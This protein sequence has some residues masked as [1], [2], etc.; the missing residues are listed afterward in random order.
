MDGKKQLL[1]GLYNNIVNITPLL[2]DYVGRKISLFI[3]ARGTSKYNWV[4]YSDPS[5]DET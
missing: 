5:D 3:S 4:E 1:Y 2:D